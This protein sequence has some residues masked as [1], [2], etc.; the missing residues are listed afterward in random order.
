MQKRDVQALVIKAPLGK[1]AAFKPAATGD[2]SS[3]SV[4]NSAGMFRN[5][6]IPVF[7]SNVGSNRHEKVI[8]ETG[9]QGSF[10]IDIPGNFYT[11]EGLKALGFT[12]SRRPAVATYLK[13]DK[14]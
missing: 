7:A 10:D 13:V 6:P 8:D 9:I 5:C 2:S 1:P 11:D 3:M 14:R 12:L 4:S